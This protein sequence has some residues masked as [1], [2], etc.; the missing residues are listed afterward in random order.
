MTELL[1]WKNR[2]MDK[3]RREINRLFDCSR[4]CLEMSSFLKQ[5]SEGFRIHISETEDAVVV[6]AVL[7]GVEPG[8]LDVSVSNDT[9][10]TIKGK[11]RTENVGGDTYYHCARRSLTSFSR[12]FCLPCRVRVAETRATFRDGILD[13]VLPKWRAGKA[14]EIKVDVTSS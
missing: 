9:L 4:S 10:L 13:M 7:E 11:R 14:R 3:L 5:I 12:S 2:E 6:E 8:D 1:L